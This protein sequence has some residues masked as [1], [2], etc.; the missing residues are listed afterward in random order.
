MKTLIGLMSG[1]GALSG[2]LVFLAGFFS[3]GMSIYGLYLA[4]SASIVLGIL[5]FL[6]QPSPLVFGVVM[7]FFDK[8][9][10]QMIVDFLNS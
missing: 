10:P 7:F 5:A 9:L 4:F 1:L 8:N 6:I 2:I 3:F